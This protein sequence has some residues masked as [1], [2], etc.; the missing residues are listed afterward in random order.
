MQRR[1]DDITAKKKK[2]NTFFNNMIK[3][4]FLSKDFWTQT[5]VRPLSSKLSNLTL[6]RAALLNNGV[7]SRSKFEMK[8]LLLFFFRSKVRKNVCGLSPFSPPA[9]LISGWRLKAFY[10][11]SRNDSEEKKSRPISLE[12]DK[13]VSTVMVS[14]LLYFFLPF[15]GKIQF[16][17][18]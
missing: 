17:S 11:S 16:S 15:I 7:C 6:S 3:F 8:S 1:I 10:F 18:E 12:M 5:L 4:S 2:K 13:R 9:H 14:F